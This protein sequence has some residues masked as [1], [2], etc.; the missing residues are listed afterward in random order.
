M[1]KKTSYT[2]VCFA[3]P[4]E[5]PRRWNDNIKTDLREACSGFGL[6]T[7][8]IDGVS[9][10]G[11]NCSVLLIHSIHILLYCNLIASYKAYFKAMKTWK[12][13]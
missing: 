11:A 6:R 1:R 9:I 10:L 8:S 12:H 4:L 7:V 3:K 2:D 13:R 5:I